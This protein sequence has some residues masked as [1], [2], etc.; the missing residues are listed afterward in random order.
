M[1]R[2]DWV[3]LRLSSDG[4]SAQSLFK[5]TPDVN[6]RIKM[7]PLGVMMRVEVTNQNSYPVKVRGLRV[8][9]TVVNPSDGDIFFGG[10]TKAKTPA[11]LPY[12]S[13]NIT[14]DYSFDVEDFTL[15]GKQK[16]NKYFL[17]WGM[18]T[19]PNTAGTAYYKGRKFSQFLL[20]VEFLNTSIAE[21]DRPKMTTLYVWGSDANT[22]RHNSRAK[23]DAQIIRPQSVLEY[24]SKGY[25]TQDRKFSPNRPLYQITKA[26]FNREKTLYPGWR[27]L[28]YLEADILGNAALASNMKRNPTAAGYKE[29]LNLNYPDKVGADFVDLAVRKGNNVETEVLYMLRFDDKV[30]NG[31][32]NRLQYSAWRYKRNIGNRYGSIESIY[33]GPAFKGTIWDVA[34]EKFWELHQADIVTRV[35]SSAQTDYVVGGNTSRNKL[36]DMPDGPQY[37]T[38]LEYHKFRGEIL[39]SHID[40]EYDRTAPAGTGKRV[41]HFSIGENPKNG[42]HFMSIGCIGIHGERNNVE[43]LTFCKSR[44][45]GTQCTEPRD[46][47]ETEPF[48]MY[49]NAPKYRW[50]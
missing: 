2:F 16:Y 33:L 5:D 46:V 43:K 24:Y 4:I 20:D 9:S 15:T 31:A 28:K 49:M 12:S 47:W 41:L 45:N 42:N 6:N 29:T 48:I 27:A 40:E 10:H 26:L 32:T 1:Q 17:L 8:F 22:P 13:Q 23:I 11:D 19:R 30:T 50:K 14:E 3:P 44:P 38:D 7:K 21:E 35:Y 39:Y 25:A 36:W 34:T 18:P 37:S